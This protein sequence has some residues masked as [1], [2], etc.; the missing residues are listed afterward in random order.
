MHYFLYSLARLKLF[1]LRFFLFKS[2]KER[3]VYGN[4]L[5]DMICLFP[6]QD[7][8]GLLIFKIIIY[9]YIYIY[10]FIIIVF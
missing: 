7:R 8:R 2:M 3:K 9:I 5:R 4:I 6:L 10:I 1:M